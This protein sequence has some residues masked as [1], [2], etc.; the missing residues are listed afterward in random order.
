M[1]TKLQVFFDESC[2]ICQQVVSYLSRL[3][4]SD[5]VEFHAASELDTFTTN[6]D[7]LDSRYLDMVGLAE[8]AS[9]RGYETYVQIASRFRYVPQLSVLM[10]LPGVRH[11][12]ELIYRRVSRS[13]TCKV[14]PPQDRMPGTP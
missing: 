5:L 3:C 9:F 7:L 13:R 8:N 12:G 11:V 10:A 2:G 14:A 6:R 1:A 4:R